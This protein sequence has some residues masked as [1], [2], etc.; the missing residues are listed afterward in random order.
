MEKKGISNPWEHFYIDKYK[1][2]GEWMQRGI[3]EKDGWKEN[4]A[5]EKGYSAL[6]KSIQKVKETK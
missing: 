1:C 2:S 6:E 3:D 5:L 4:N